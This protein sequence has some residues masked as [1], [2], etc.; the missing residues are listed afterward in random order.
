MQLN[1]LFEEFVMPIVAATATETERSAPMPRT[2]VSDWKRVATSGKTADGRDID[3]QD[4]RDMA[5]AY[6]PDVYTAT[7]WFEHIRYMGNFGS[8]TELKTEDQGEGKVALFAKLAPNDRLLQLNKDAQKLF[9]SIEIQPNFADTGKA[10]LR[11]LAV[12]DE[13]ASLGTAQLHFSRRAGTDHCFTSTEPLGDLTAPE[14]SDES[15]LNFFTRLFHQLSGKDVPIP[16]QHE[17]P[18]MDPKTA[19]A[20]AAAVD[21][22]NTVATSLEKSATA[23]A[24]QKAT[25]TAEPQKTETADPTPVTD[26]TAGS[27]ITSDQFNNLKTSLDQLTESFNTALN[28][29]KGKDVPSTTGAVTEEPEAVY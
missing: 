17:T 4:L 28:Q 2:F 12:T 19:E 3:P 21:K 8:V 10:Y 5:E 13:P 7:I 18:S 1:R 23:F 15:A 24:A 16:P 25:S 29:G 27:G 20:F 6:N 14:V 9:P 22:L 11:G 26:C